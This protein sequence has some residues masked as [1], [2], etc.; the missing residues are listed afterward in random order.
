MVADFG[1]PTKNTNNI[2]KW[3]NRNENSRRNIKLKG[4]G[5]LGIE[6]ENKQNS[7]RKIRNRHTKQ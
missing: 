4:G 6:K 2:Q 1:F 3:G 7:K 5:K